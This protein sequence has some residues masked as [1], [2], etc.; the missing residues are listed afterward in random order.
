VKKLLR[1]ISPIISAILFGIALY[2]IHY[3]LRQ[4]HY[5]DIVKEVRLIPLLPLMASIMLAFFNYFILTGYDT[6]AMRYIGQKLKYPQIAFASF[7]GYA[8]GHNATVL[9]GSAARYRIYSSLGIGAFDIGR[10]VIFNTLTFWLGF[11]FTGGIFFLFQ[12]QEIP[13]SFHL[14]FTSVR[15]LGIVF[16]ILIL[17]YLIIAF[18]VKDSLKIKQHWEFKMPS[19]PICFE[20]IALSCVDWLA[21]AS[22]LY[23]LLPPL[24][25][26]TYAKF[27][28][29]F[30][31]AQ[32]IGMMSSVPGG[33]GIFE[34]VILLLLSDY[35]ATAAITA[36]IIV[37]RMVYYLLPLTIASVLLGG[38]ELITNRQRVK[39]IGL[40]FRSNIDYLRSPSR[41]ERPPG[42]TGRLSASAGDR[43]VAFSG[44][45]CWG[46]TFN[47]CTRAAKAN[48]RGI[49]FHN[50]AACSRNTIF[51][52]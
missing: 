49:S 42:D 9:G 25:G 21:A 37:Y 8:F 2:V 11:L 44:E 30:L 4:Y 41:C 46:G 48:Q 43:T 17:I 20:Q 36:S 52:V 18:F 26:L 35:E 24:A 12:P 14:P 51:T 39:K 40:V 5:R 6:L 15:P 32:I 23:V 19:M 22:V 7:I 16:L 27:V 45:H 29:I 1:N 33:L 50:Y 3:K 28:G 31:L 38:H 47:P 10:L 34:T 13:E